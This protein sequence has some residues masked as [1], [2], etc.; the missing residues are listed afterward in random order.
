MQIDHFVMYLWFVYE[1]KKNQVFEK[2]ENKTRKSA[3]QIHVLFYMICINQ[4]SGQK[5]HLKINY[6][7]VFIDLNLKNY[8]LKLLDIIFSYF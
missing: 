3:D 2:S 4:Y 7:L 6:R 5:L 8:V 1:D